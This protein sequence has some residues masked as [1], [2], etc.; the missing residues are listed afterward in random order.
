MQ[1]GALTAVSTAKHTDNKKRNKS[2]GRGT[3][4][5]LEKF[6][7]S[8]KKEREMENSLPEHSMAN[9]KVTATWL[10]ENSTF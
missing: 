10:E 5:P 4:D 9:L 6:Q 8:A 7:A 2:K 1:S 3:K